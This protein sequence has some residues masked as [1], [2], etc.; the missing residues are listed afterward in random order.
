ML[1]VA[2]VRESR[3]A[4]IPAVV[5]VDGTARPQ[6]VSRRLQ[7]RFHELLRAFERRTG[8][9]VLL[10][11]SFNLAGEPIVCTPADAVRCFRRTHMDVLVLENFIL[12][13]A[14]QPP[15]PVDES[16]KAEFALD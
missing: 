12:E 15:M 16:W 5:H 6:L 13:R 10:N 3:R 14:A 1:L 8:V 9:A 11:T 7:P 2:P 4:E